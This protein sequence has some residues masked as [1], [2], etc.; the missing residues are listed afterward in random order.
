MQDFFIEPISR[1]A[2]FALFVIAIVIIAKIINIII[3]KVIHSIKMKADPEYKK[4]YYKKLIKDAEH[5][6]MK[7]K[8][9]EAEQYRKEKWKD[10][11]NP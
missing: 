9:N 10:P 8:L 6:H 7:Y 4:Q 2:K 3:K 11:Y 5:S 1:N